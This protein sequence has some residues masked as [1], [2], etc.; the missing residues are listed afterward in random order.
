[1]NFQRNIDV[2]RRLPFVNPNKLSNFFGK[3]ILLLKNPPIFTRHN[4][5][6]N[7][8]SLIII[9]KIT[10]TQANIYYIY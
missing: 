4:N 8:I 1:M 5:T 10:L 2:L 9:C 7:G 3:G 6:R